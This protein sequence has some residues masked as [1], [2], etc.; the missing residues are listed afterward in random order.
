MIVGIRRG[1]IVMVMRRGLSIV[2]Q[3]GGNQKEVT[4][5]AMRH[6]V[7]GPVIYAAREDAEENRDTGVFDQTILRPCCR[8]TIEGST[9]LFVFEEFPRTARNSPGNANAFRYFGLPRG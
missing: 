8:N 7:A 9:D 3:T 5:A 1:R 4:L 2:P 6:H